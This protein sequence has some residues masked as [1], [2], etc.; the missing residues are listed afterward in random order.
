MGLSVCIKVTVSSEVS[1]TDL[2]SKILSVSPLANN[3]TKAN[4]SEDFWETCLRERE[5]NEKTIFRW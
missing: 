4:C 1:A 2:L 5:E 3:V